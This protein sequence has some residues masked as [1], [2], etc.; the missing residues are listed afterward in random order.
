MLSLANRD[1][2]ETLRA[3][4]EVG[5]DCTFIVPTQ[6]GL[7]KSILDATET[8]RVWFKENHLHDYAAQGQGQDYKVQI[9]ALIIARGEVADTTASLYRPETKSGDPRI[10]FSRLGQHAD[11]TDL[12]AICKIGKKVLIVNCSNNDLSRLLSD[13]S[14]VFWRIFGSENPA[15]MQV[16]KVS[17][18]DISEI[19]R[20]ANESSDSDL[21]ENERLSSRPTLRIGSAD[22]TLEALELLSMLKQIGAKGFVPTMRS[23][24]TGVGF[25]LETLL[26]I[27]CNSSKSP[28]YKGIEIKAGRASAHASGR[29]TIFS[30]VPD[31]SISRLKGSK[32]ILRER[33]R[34]HEVK[35][36]LQL[37]HE[38]SATKINSYGLSLKVDTGNEFLHQIYVK[39]GQSVIDVTWTLSQLFDRLIEKHKQ[40]FWVKAET[41]GRGKGEQ[42]HYSKA[43]YTSG[44]SP[45]KFPMLLETGIISLDYTIKALPNGSAKDQ[46][47]L[48]KIKQ[49]DLP[50]LF[51]SPQTFDLTN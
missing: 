47:Y 11:P 32:D 14:S 15:S 9:E 39:E 2:A 35:Q 22:L 4:S 30:Q 3:F 43:K 10:W 36:R 46:G 5:V 13:S 38:M 42:F 25:T 49:N 44:V 1:V 19:L 18:Q 27:E 37:F 8:V 24:D 20:Y 6:T 17:Q 41:Q 40:T 31:W 28:D 29:T 23:G 33:G 7:Q 34:F 26:G 16:S 45:S 12:L 48:F 51:K 21:A 50:L